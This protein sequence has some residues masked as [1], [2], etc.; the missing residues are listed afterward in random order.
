MITQLDELPEGVL[1]FVV[2]GKVSAEDYRDVVI[3]ALERAA[4]EG[5]VR[6]LVVIKDFKGFSGGAFWQDL[7]VGAEHFRSWKR[8]ALVTDVEWMHHVTSLV[9]WLTPGQI[10]TFPNSARDDAISWLLE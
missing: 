6:W 2:G 8:I 9:G 3:P 1:G 4:A 10:R 7:K 5:D